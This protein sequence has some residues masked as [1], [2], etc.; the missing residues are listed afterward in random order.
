[1]SHEDG[2]GRVASISSK[3]CGSDPSEVPHMDETVQQG[4]PCLYACHS[5]DG[6]ISG[7]KR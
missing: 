7:T 1:M 4:T 2:E 3:Q 5:R 6:T